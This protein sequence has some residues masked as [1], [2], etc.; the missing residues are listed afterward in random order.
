MTTMS[1]T[2]MPLTIS[3]FNEWGNPNIKKYFD[4]ILSYCPY[5][6]IK[7]MSYPNIFIITGFYDTRVKYHE[8]LK[9]IT[10]L[11]E[12]KTDK[13]TQLLKIEMDSGHVSSTNLYKYTE[14]KALIYYMS[15]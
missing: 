8:S 9:F 13:N 6:N 10:K 1:D 5:N 15:R 4:Y 11:R 12:H 2:S 14:E 3:E 7:R